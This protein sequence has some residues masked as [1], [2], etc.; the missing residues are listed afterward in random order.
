M[1]TILT[2][3]GSG[4]T[5]PTM[6]TTHRRLVEAL[7]ADPVAVL[8]DTPYGFQENADEVTAKSLRYFAASVG[9]DV[10]VVS[11]RRADEVGPVRMETILAEVGEAD[12]VFAGPGSPTYLVRQWAQTGLREVL[13]ARL[14]TG[15]ATVFASAAAVTIGARAVPVYEI[16]KAGADPHWTDG[17]DLLS[18]VGLDAVCIPHFD[19]A[20]GGTHDTRFCY[21]GERRLAALEALLPASTWVLGVDEHTALVLDLTSGRAIVEGRGAVTVRARDVTVRFPAGRDIAVEELI[22]AAQG[23]ASPVPASP[24]DDSEPDHAD[25]AGRTA[26]TAEQTPLEEIVGASARAFDAA[27]GQGRAM[28]A[29]ERTVALDAQ[30]RDWATDVAELDELD[31]GHAELRRQITML[32]RAA[33]AG[34]HEHRDLVAPHVEILLRLRDRARA[35]GRFDE[36][37]AIRDTI[38]AAGVEVRDTADGVTWIFAEPDAAGQG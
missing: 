6:V 38:T 23:T 16:Y 21:L 17:L 3:M 9:I 35:E 32:A 20:D 33:Q 8:L 34:M 26:G 7:G 36:A 2:I 11:L 19:N 29:A 1:P 14:R 28:D 37:D 5:T 15:G 22:S 31:R 25:A 30:L 24:S 27:M 13:A 12:W 4:E 10:G 18:G